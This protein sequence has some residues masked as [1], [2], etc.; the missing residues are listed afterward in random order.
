MKKALLVISAGVAL[1]ALSACSHYTE[2]TTA[3]GTTVKHIAPGTSV[4]TNSGGCIN[5]AGVTC[6]QQGVTTA[7]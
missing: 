4:T 1:C 5:S 2:A 7:Q 3:N 6:E